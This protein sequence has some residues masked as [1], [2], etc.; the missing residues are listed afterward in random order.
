MS[1][2]HTPEEL[3]EMFLDLISPQVF[4]KNFPTKQ[5]FKEWLE[6][7][8]ITDL[9]CTLQKFSDAELYEDCVLIKNV[10]NKKRLKKLMK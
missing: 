8:T 5:L 2:K 9:E 4:R 3:E 10:I 7:G 6:F 1:N